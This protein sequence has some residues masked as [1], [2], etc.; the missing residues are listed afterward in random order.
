MGG[1]DSGQADGLRHSPTQRAEIP[2]NAQAQ[3][4]SDKTDAPDAATLSL[5]ESLLDNG[6]T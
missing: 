2:T 6:T 5:G 4:Q 1:A 3:K